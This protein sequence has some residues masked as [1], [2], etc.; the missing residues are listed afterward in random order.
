MEKQ[1]IDLYSEKE[2]L[3]REIH[4]SN[5]ILIVHMIKNMERQLKELYEEKRNYL[6]IDANQIIIQGAKKIIIRKKSS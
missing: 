2:F 3:E 6:V 5:P 1:L 4:T